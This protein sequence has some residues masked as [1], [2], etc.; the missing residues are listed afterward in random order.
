MT[1]VC[2]CCDGSALQW[3]HAL[4]Q[5]KRFLPW[6]SFG[7]NSYLVSGTF[8]KSIVYLMVLFACTN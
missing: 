6:S 5:A 4:L 7:H 1:C 2:V 8:V 3:G